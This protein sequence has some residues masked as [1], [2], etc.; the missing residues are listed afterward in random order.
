MAAR[1]SYN[2]RSRRMSVDR[3][4]KEKD[5]GKDKELEENRKVME[6]KGHRS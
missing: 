3:E 1:G 2:C 4:R 6:G 5:G